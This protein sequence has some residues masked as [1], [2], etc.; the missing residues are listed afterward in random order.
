M[1]NRLRG[2]P[3]ETAQSGGEDKLMKQQCGE[4]KWVWQQVRMNEGAS[5]KERMQGYKF[6]NFFGNKAF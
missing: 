4:V 1:A 3:S 2:G 5:K 6:T